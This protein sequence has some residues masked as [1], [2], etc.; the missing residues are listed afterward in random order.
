M[1]KTMT[2]AVR[3]TRELGL[4]VI[5]AFSPLMMGANGCI[6]TAEDAAPLSAEAFCASFPQLGFGNLFYCGTSQSN[7]Q[8]VAFP[9]GA[10]GYCQTA[11]EN[12][13]LV[14]YSVTMYNGG[15]S[16]VMSQS[17]ASQLSGALGNQSP[18]Y[19]RCT[20]Q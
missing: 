8:L 1:I 5:V 16:A 13:G 18:G 6:P 11:D 14:G 2:V 20:R 15:I 19:I 12:L 4:F 17:R 3:W 9:D 10:R 7:L